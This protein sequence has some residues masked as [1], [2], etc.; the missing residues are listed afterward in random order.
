MLPTCLPFPLFRD[1]PPP[2]VRSL[3]C[4]FILTLRGLSP[5]TLHMLTPQ[6]PF[7]KQHSHQRKVLG[8]RRPRW[9]S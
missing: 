2:T 5:K 4:I 1:H 9:D 7:E 3:S 6:V 8:A